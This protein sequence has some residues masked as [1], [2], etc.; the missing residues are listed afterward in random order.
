MDI[1]DNHDDQSYKLVSG[2]LKG[3]YG[4]FEGR[5]VEPIVPTAEQVE[6]AIAKMA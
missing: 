3:Q 1:F 2:L 5:M 4:W 6:E